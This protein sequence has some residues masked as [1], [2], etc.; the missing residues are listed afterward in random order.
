MGWDGFLDGAMLRTPSVLIM[1]MIIIL[2]K[3]KEM[4]TYSL[5]GQVEHLTIEEGSLS[6]LDGDHRLGVAKIWT[7]HK[8]V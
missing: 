7:R 8:F 1:I 4:T 2:L 5:V 6:L 3:K